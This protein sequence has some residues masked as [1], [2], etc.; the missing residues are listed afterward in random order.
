[1]KYTP[2]RLFAELMHQHDQLR[3][4]INQCELLA[5]EVDEGRAEPEK[6]TRE[7]AKLR[8]AFEAHNKFEEELLRPVLRELDAFGDVRVDRMVT[9]HV[10]EHRSLRDGLQ[11][12]PT[13]LLRST[14]DSLRVHLMAEEKY[15]MTSKVLRDD[16]ITVESGG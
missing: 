14:I 1:M 15:F 13:G 8:I 7:V 10:D 3:V 12:G 2:S 6:L 9:A 11:S 4:M 16:V 5:D